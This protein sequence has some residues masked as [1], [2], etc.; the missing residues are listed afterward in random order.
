MAFNNNPIVDENSE[1]SEESVSLTKQVF[2]RKSKFITREEFP[3]YGVDLDIELM[4]ESSEATARKFAVQIKSTKSAK[5]VTIDDT[6]YLSLPF[7]TSRLGYLARRIPVSGLIVVYDEFHSK[8]YYDYAETIISRINGERNSDNW[9]NQESVNIHIPLENLLDGDSVN[10]IHNK[11][12][13]KF[14]NFELLFLEYSNIESNAESFPKSKDEKISLKDLEDYGYIL[15]NQQDFHILKTIFSNFSFTE[16]VSYPKLCLYATITYCE[17]GYAI[18]SLSYLYQCKRNFE[19][20]TNYELELIKIIEPKIKLLVGDL[21]IEEYAKIIELSLGDMSLEL[22]KVNIKINLYQVKVAQREFNEKFE[23]KLILFFDD[24]EKL[25]IEEKVKQ[26]LFVQ[27]SQVIFNYSISYF[28][29]I[30]TQQKIRENIGRP[31]SSE[32]KI[33]AYRRYLKLIEVPDEYLK[34]AYDFA[35]DTKDEI[36][37]S[38]V[39]LHK[40]KIFLNSNLNRLMMMQVQALDEKLDNLYKWHMNAIITAYNGFI[41]ESR[42]KEAHLAL[43]IAEEMNTMYFLV[44]SKQIENYPEGKIETNIKA[45]ESETGLQ[46]Y[47]PMVEEG[48][49][50]TLFADL[51]SGRFISSLPLKM[52]EVFA[53]ELFNAYQLPKDRYQNILNDLLTFHK[54]SAVCDNEDIELL[55]EL[56]HTQSIEQQRYLSSL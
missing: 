8:L 18:Q 5:F 10:S 12:T 45:I 11:L 3:D 41:K 17:T 32:D 47:E 13:H 37:E 38:E 36:L 21:S 22:N 14:K 43:N 27:H 23:E 25:T 48:L 46:S 44:Y 20:Y 34:R 40:G 29:K 6:K 52:L 19:K 2:S 53:Q 35:I 7:K 28:S 55:Q 49:K 51:N 4:N 42:F 15:I 56:Q 30:F 31:L 24:I 16:I 39:L 54:F 9:K 33:H 50:K 26:S 1:R